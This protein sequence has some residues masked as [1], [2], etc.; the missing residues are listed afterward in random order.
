MLLFDVADKNAWCLIVVVVVIGCLNE[1]KV[2]WRDRILI[3][4]LLSTVEL[5][6]VVDVIAPLRNFYC[7]PGFS[8]HQGRRKEKNLS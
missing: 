4:L 3:Y 1:C 6:Q 2:L 8:C 7:H 5:F